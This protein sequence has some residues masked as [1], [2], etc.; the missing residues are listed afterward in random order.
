M[1]PSSTTTLLLI[2]HGHNGAVG[3]WLAGW[4][5]GVHLSDEGREQA[6]RLVDRLRGVR[7][8]AIYTSPLDRTR[9]TAAPLASDR[10]LE[11]REIPEI[12]EFRMGEFDGQRFDAL[13]TDARWRRF[14]AVRSVVRPPGG[15]LML[16]LQ[17]RMVGALLEIADRHAGGSVVVFS[18]ADPIRA[19]ILYFAG[20]PIDF[21]YRL[22]VAPASLT[23]IALRLGGP[24]IVKMNDTGDIQGLPVSATHGAG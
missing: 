11:V 22:D 3:Q 12:G 17:S 13:E 18:H 20:M 2:R 10:G 1:A 14:N 8:D 5:A 4:R 16:E 9:E 15:E 24:A 6:R 7:I 19:A 23:A 21:F